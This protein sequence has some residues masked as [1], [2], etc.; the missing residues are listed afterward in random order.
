MADGFTP[1]VGGGAAIGKLAQIGDLSSQVSILQRIIPTEAI[2][3]FE[4]SF[5]VMFSMSS[6]RDPIGMNF[7]P[8]GW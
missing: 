8:E 1:D 5:F 3:A 7:T 6:I 4:K 2:I